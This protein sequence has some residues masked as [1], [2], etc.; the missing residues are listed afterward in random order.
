[1]RVRGQWFVA[2][3]L[4]L[5]SLGSAAPALAAPMVEAV[6]DVRF[7]SRKTG[8]F[9]KITISETGDGGLAFRVELLDALGSHADLDE[10]YFNLPSGIR[11]LEIETLG[12]VETPFEVA[13]G[14][15]VRGGAGSDFDVA[16]SFGNGRG[17]KGN[18]QLQVA[19]FVLRAKQPLTLAAVLGETSETSQGIVTN[20]AV[21][22]QGS[23]GGGSTVGGFV[24]P[25]PSTALL[26]AT[27]LLGLAV[28]GRRA[29]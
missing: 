13:M 14:S 1:M 10:L 8:E 4:A 17:R 25:E 15:A 21:H 9:A 24:V 29:R 16:V 12:K 23:K 6:L 27:G 19:S 28:F 11:G 7:G 2:L 26:A 20:F 5:A 22:T 3:A 18:G